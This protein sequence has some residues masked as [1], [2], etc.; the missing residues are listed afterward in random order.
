MAL[1][2]YHGRTDL[3]RA[4]RK[5][6]SDARTLLSAGRLHSLG[7]AYMAGYAVECMIKAVAMEVYH[8]WTLQE[9][10]ANL[11]IDERDIYTHG[12]EIL[13]RHLPSYNRFIRSDVGRLHF[14]ARVVQWRVSWRYNPLNW[15]TE[16]ARLFIESCE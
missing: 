15:E 5:R 14:A 4:S 12:L 8:C 16:K 1:R 10:A 13:L 2:D 7:A 6:L 3:L 9:L 11:K